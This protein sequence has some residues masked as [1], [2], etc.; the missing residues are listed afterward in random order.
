[1]GVWDG[2]GLQEASA[3][4]TFPL[5]LLRTQFREI[6]FPHPNYSHDPWDL[7]VS[8]ENGGAHTPTHIE[9]EEG[10]QTLTSLRPCRLGGPG[11][12]SVV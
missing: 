8:R 1:M 2:L 12:L 7:S 5:I 4:P 3:Q 6:L 9:G 10:Q 11:C